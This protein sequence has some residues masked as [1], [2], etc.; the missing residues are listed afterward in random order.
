LS[1]TMAPKEAQDIVYQA[2]RVSSAQ[3]RPHL[4]TISDIDAELHRQGLS[5]RPEDITTELKN[6]EVREEYLT[7][8]SHVFDD[9]MDFSSQLAEATANMCKTTAGEI[10]RLQTDIDLSSAR[11]KEMV[12]MIKDILTSHSLEA[13]RA[14]EESDFRAAFESSTSEALD[15]LR[16]RLQT[17][18]E[19]VD[20]KFQEVHREMLRELQ[21]EDFKK[22]FDDCVKSAKSVNQAAQVSVANMAKELESGQQNLADLSTQLRDRTSRV[23]NLEAEA[24]DA[25][26]AL[27]EK[28]SRVAHLESETS[29]VQQALHD[30]T[31]RVETL[32]GELSEAGKAA[33]S[34]RDTRD[35]TIRDLQRQLD[36]KTNRVET[37]E[38]ELL[39]TQK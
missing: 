34:E 37:L 6:A 19:E 35:A 7:T 13:E 5:T 8:I 39:G 14:F 4:E 2:R 21:F 20:T 23:A 36:A 10:K 25:R 16:E 30:K 26:K 3:M 17:I 1:S 27:D 9:R 32:E 38:G 24:S 29:D 12:D 22:T 28:T 33:R 11:S 18:W 31:T 15:E